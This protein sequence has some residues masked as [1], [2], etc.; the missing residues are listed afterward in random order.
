MQIFHK[1]YSWQLVINFEL[2]DIVPTFK[3]RSVSRFG[4]AYY[5]CYVLKSSSTLLRS[6]FLILQKHVQIQDDCLSEQI[7]HMNIM[8]EKKSDFKDN[9]MTIGVHC[10]LYPRTVLLWYFVIGEILSQC[11]SYFESLLLDLCCSIIC[12]YFVMM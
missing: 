12:I 1:A 4:N 2:I 6:Y 7:C 11:C 8:N 10:F 9:A 5:F 3:H